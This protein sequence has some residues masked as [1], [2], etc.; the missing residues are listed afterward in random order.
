MDTVHVWKMTGLAW[1]ATDRCILTRFDVSMI[2]CL[3]FAQIWVVRVILDTKNIGISFVLKKWPICRETL[4]LAHFGAFRHFYDPVLRFGSNLG[5]KG[6]F[7]NK[8]HW[9]TVHD[10]K[11]I[12]SA[13]NA[14]DRCILTRFDVSMILR[15]DFAQIWVVRVILDI[16]NIEI[17]FMSKKWPVCRKMPPIGAFWRVSTFP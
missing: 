7:T 9:D 15:F 11:M 2:L 12:S 5:C 4:P 1:N 6:C 3:D 10:K 14:T 16:K 13:W 17:P 8:K